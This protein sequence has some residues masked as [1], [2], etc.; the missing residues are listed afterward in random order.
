VR[1]IFNATPVVSLISGWMTWLI[2][3]WADF[4]SVIVAWKAFWGK[5]GDVFFWLAL[6]S[7]IAGVWLFF[8]VGILI[9]IISTI[10]LLALVMVIGHMDAQDEDQYRFRDRL[11]G[12]RKSFEIKRPIIVLFV[13]LFI[14]LPNTF[15]GYDAGVPFQD[16]KEHD[17]A[18]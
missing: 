8:T 14:F 11:T 17:I 13:G 2:I 7:T 15:Y 18:V 9:G 3:Q 12:L 10:I 5:R 4:P 6:T 16:K 1:F